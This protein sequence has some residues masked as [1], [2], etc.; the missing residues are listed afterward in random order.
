MS[1]KQRQKQFI[2]K[3]RTK[4]SA[5]QMADELNV[6]VQ[7]VEDFLEQEGLLLDPRKKA[8]FTAIAIS[9]PFVL[10]A[11]LEIALRIGNYRGD[12]RLFIEAEIE[13]VEYMLPN[14]NFAS[15]YFFYT[16]TIPNPSQ[17]LFLKNKPGN[18]FRVFVM[19]GSTAAGYPYGYNAMFSRTVRDALMD[20]MPGSEVEVINVATSAINTYTLYDQVDEILEFDPDL[21]LIYSGH[22]EYYGALGVASNESLGGFP[23]FVRLYLKLQRL[24]TFLLM[25]DAITSVAGQ[26]A[27]RSGQSGMDPGGTLMER[28]VAEQ[29]IE[30]GGPVYELGK[31]QFESNLNAIVKK[32]ERK[33]VPVFI[34]SLASNL[35]DQPPFVSVSSDNHPDAMDVYREAQ[36]LY[37]S[38][39]FEN[40]KE[41]FIQAKDLDGL[42]F[43]APE[44]MNDIIREVAERP[45]VYYVPVLEKFSEFAENGIIGEDLM[46]EHLH[47]NDRG[48]FLLGM[49][50]VDALAE[51][52]FLGRATA[53]GNLQNYQSYYD[54][55]YLTEYDRQIAEHRVRILKSGWPFVQGER[56]PNYALTYEPVSLP[57]SLAFRVVHHGMHWDRAKVELADQYNAQGQWQLALLEY[58]GLVRNQPWN[59]SPLV[60]AAR[61]HLDRNNF[62]EARPYLENAYKINQQSAYINKMLGAIEVNDGNLE[63]GIEL[64]NKSL[65]IN[66]DDPQA[67]FNLS[68]A[69]GLQRDFQKAR[70]VLDKLIAI[71][72]NFPGA[73]QWNQQLR[74]LE[75]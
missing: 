6:S 36:A 55:M 38:G 35:K 70:E 44:A 15:R 50:F 60:Y 46:L 8:I 17:D 69:Y 18:G 19:G 73:R 43:R 71:N 54:R 7:E 5:E 21:I 52:N 23:G 10:F 53:T 41:A 74:S 9:I 39:E 40:A 49:S 65:Q 64:L 61:L 32:F 30:Y 29:A 25:R 22:N 28:I 68:G 12:T 16:R 34:G 1:L 3:N 45:N 59:D 48:Y 51:N 75:R 2:R 27:E 4:K 47:P 14:Q 13:N 11:I 63:R 67:L 56:L 42:K 24:K 66:P 72:P 57:D 31:R 37:E 26:L 58:D 20:V 33:D 62:A